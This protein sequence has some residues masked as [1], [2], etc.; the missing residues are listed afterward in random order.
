MEK[1]RI[2]ELVD[3]RRKSDKTRKKTFA[4]KLKTR[5]AKEKK[6]EDSGGGNYWIISS[7]S[8]LKVFKTD[9]PDYYDSKIDEVSQKLSDTEIDNTKT[10]Y[11]RNIDI[12]TAFKDF[13]F[14][15]LKPITNLKYRTVSRTS[16][17]L[18]VK[19]FPLF[20]N[21]DALFSYTINGKDEIGALWL[22]QQQDGFSK[23]ELGMFCEILYRFL[24]RN[25]GADFQISENFCTVI[26]T[27]G[28]Q[29]ITYSDMLS[30]GAIF[31]IDETLEEIQTL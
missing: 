24:V 13:D 17:I 19:G 10:M 7:S 29:R 28:A 22:I 3:F 1:I 14:S 27:C 26:D 20:I 16:Q 2:K 21:P 8:I 12:L 9:D 11:Q 25:Y 31:L 5:T 6:D 15:D 18:T 30:E 4:Q 23:S